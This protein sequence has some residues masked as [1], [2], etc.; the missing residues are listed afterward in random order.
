MDPRL[1]MALQL[2][3]TLPSL[4]QAGADIQALLARWNARLA[5]MAASGRKPTDAE[6]DELNAEIDTLRGQLHQG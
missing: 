4:I 2:L 3:Q 1:L 6:W 5:D